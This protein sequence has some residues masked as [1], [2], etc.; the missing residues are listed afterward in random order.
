[1]AQAKFDDGNAGRRMPHRAPL[2]QLAA[3]HQP[4]RQGDRCR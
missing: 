3:D 1:M 4:I 2:Q